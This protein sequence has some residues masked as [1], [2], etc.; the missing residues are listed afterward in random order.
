MVKKKISKD[1]TEFLKHVAIYEELDRQLNNVRDEL[2]DA[3]YECI[4]IL[5]NNEEPYTKAECVDIM[6]FI[7]RRLDLSITR[8]NNYMIDIKRE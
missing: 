2:F 4:E 8:A 1:P 5:E 7:K 3:V 6:Q